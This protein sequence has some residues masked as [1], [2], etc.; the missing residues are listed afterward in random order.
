MSGRP[1]TRPF[2][3]HG[4]PAFRKNRVPILAVE[5]PSST[6]RIL[7]STRPLP[8]ALASASLSC[9]WVCP[10]HPEEAGVPMAEEKSRAKAGPQMQPRTHL[11]F[12]KLLS[13][14]A[15]ALVST[16]QSAGQLQLHI[17]I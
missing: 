4:S 11:D 15:S 8:C 16:Q 7:P 13:V 3:H 1:R 12:A 10:V 2:W 5:E 9:A 14:S 17:I 6:S